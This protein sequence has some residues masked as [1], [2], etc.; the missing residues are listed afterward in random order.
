MWRCTVCRKAED[1]RK[2][3]RHHYWTR[4]V[5][6]K[7]TMLV[8]DGSCHN[9]ADYVTQAYLEANRIR[10][11]TPGLVRRIYAQTINLRG[12]FEEFLLP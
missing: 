1:R 6:T 9:F 8:H 11:V 12:R 3:V 10:E 2:L 5:D 4:K 7:R